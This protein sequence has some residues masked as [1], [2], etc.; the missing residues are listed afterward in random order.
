MSITLRP[1]Q[2]RALNQYRAVYNIGNSHLGIAPTAFGKTIL[3][4]W[5]AKKLVQSEENYRCI[6]V[7]HR[8]AL[9]RQ[10]ADKVQKVAPSLLVGIE[11]ASS[12]SSHEDDVISASIATL[13]GNRLEACV[14][15]WRS[16]GRP[17]MLFIDEAHHAASD[18][19]RR[20]IELLAPE[21][22]LGVTATPT[23]ADGKSIEDIYPE[24]GFEI[25]RSE[26]ID[27]GWLAEPLHF[28][29]HTSQSLEGMKKK[30]GDYD[31]RELAERL[32]V[33]DRDELIVNA[34][35]EGS[36]ILQ[37]IG[38]PVT[39]G[40]V[41]SISVDHAYLLEQRFKEAGWNA[42]AIEANT[43]IKDRMAADQLL[44]TSD[45]H[46]VLISYGVLT[47]G[48]DV[49]EVNLGLFTRPTKSGVLADQMLGRVLRYMEGKPNS[50]V[51][52]F[53]DRGAEDRVS[54]SSTFKLP[55]QW[56]CA[57]QGMRQ[58]EKWFQ[59][60]VQQSTFKIRGLLWEA[61]SKDEVQR[62]LA[63]AVEEN[64]EPLEGRPFLWWNCGRE[65]RM[66][67]D[68]ESIV[69]TARPQG[70]YIVELRWS[71]V[72]KTIGTYGRWLEAVEA[73]EEY[74]TGNYPESSKFLANLPDFQEPITEKQANLLS[75]KFP[76]VDTSKVT[77]RKASHLIN[78]SFMEMCQD[79]EEGRITFGKHAGTHIDEVPTNY[80][81]YM[82][83][84]RKDWLFDT[85]RPELHLFGVAL[86]SRGYSL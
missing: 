45:K 52:D 41:F 65:L 17:V 25:P 76:N 85:N 8:E 46:T 2:E 10:N 74:L 12:E 16:D 60:K 70:D 58:D 37:G 79:A 43:P 28:L 20:L 78:Q 77:K 32:V 30:K 67:L 54:I 24:L 27:D 35:L 68:K 50:L 49:E 34:A 81:Q 48:W 7:S 36:E 44:K 38:Q 5:L 59:E 84:G 82:Y 26:M 6:I 13:R 29:I 39:R 73:G 66:V 57:G 53:A 51:I 56:D 40:V 11:K 33:K 69:L 3:M 23:R 63:E 47:E 9:V 19:Y 21:R 31:E 83:T 14:K 42:V 22:H 18:S 4:G 62:I 86:Q 71:T 72:R 64:I 61:T 1:F 55:P 75:K 15:K 80:I